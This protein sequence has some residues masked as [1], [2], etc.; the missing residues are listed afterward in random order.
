MNSADHHCPSSSGADPDVQSYCVLD[1]WQDSSSHA[2]A[3]HDVL[4]LF[5]LLIRFFQFTLKL[6]ARE[7][8]SPRHDLDNINAWLQLGCNFIEPVFPV[9]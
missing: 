3:A 9:R 7:T 5:D 1:V 8:L 4:Q 2:F 6:A